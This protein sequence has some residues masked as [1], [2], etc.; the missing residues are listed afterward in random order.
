[1]FTGII[2]KTGKIRSIENGKGL[3]IMTVEGSFAGKK[4]G[5]SIAVDGCCFTITSCTKNLFTVEAMPETTRRTVINQYVKGTIVNLENPL[6]IGDSLDGHF[7]QGHIDFVGTV[8]EFKK[9][10]NAKTVTISFPQ[11]FGKYFALKGS[12]TVNG[13]SL[14]VSKIHKTAFEVSLIPQTLKTTNLGSLKK[15]DNVNIE[16]DVIARYLDSLINSKQ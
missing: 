11:K 8:K 15:N 2:R 6:K 12:V 5:D 10:G 13:V 3:K 1:M 4:I 16:I 7:V 9:D 14:T